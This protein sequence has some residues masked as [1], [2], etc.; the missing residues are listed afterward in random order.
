MTSRPSRGSSKMDDSDQIM[1]R[2]N[3]E[4]TLLKRKLDTALNMAIN[5]KITA[6]TSREQVFKDEK[7]KAWY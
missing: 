4:I 5:E 3:D 1:E 7:T 6:S 2:K